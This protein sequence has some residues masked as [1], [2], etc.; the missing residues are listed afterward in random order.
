M[1]NLLLVML[2]GA[3]G[4]GLRYAVG[5][6]AAQALGRAFPW[7]TLIVNLAGSLLIG[8]LAAWLLKDGAGDRPLWLLL[9]VGGLGGFTTFSALSLELLGMLERG[10]AATAFAYAAGS[11]VLGLA[12]AA[13]G[14]TL[15]RAAA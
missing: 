11:V 8:M 10:Q 3:A 5:L 9:A 1:P 13:C 2:G 4:A 12:L 7:G 6:Q 15:A 14:F